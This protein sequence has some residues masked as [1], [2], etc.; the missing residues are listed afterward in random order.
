MKR[1]LLI[2]LFSFIPLYLLSQKV[3]VKITE[4]KDRYVS[5]WEILDERY[6]SISSSKEYPGTDTAVFPLEANKRYFL[7]ISVQDIEYPDTCHFSLLLN[8]EPI[9]R[10]K[11]IEPGDRL[12]PFFTG[13]KTDVDSKITGGSDADISEFPWQVY[14]EAGN[15][16]C[17]GSII[18]NE[19]IITAAHCTKGEFNEPIPASEMDVIVGANNPRNPSQGKKY[20]VSDVIVHELYDLQTYNNDIAVLRLTE[21]VN[22]TNAVPIKLISEK[23][24]IAGA[25]DPGVMSW[26]IGYGITKVNPPVYPSTLQKLKLPLV[27]NEQAS[28]VWPEIPETDMM[29]GY[30]T[31]NK[32][33]CIGDSGGPLVVPVSGGYKLAGLVSWGSTQCNTYGAY[34]RLSLFESWITEKTGIEITFRAPVPA[35][36]S[37]VCSGIQSSD[38]YVAAVSGATSYNWILTPQNS[39]TITGNAER[40]TVTWNPTFTGRV[41][42]SLQVSRNAELSEVS[43]L[44]VNVAK[45][46]SLLS[47]PG[48]TSGCAGQSL[49]LMAKAEGYNLVYKWFK[50]D[51]L[52]F[53]DTTGEYT[54]SSAG[55]KDS[56]FYYCKVGGSCGDAVT[57]TSSLTVLPVT[58]ITHITPDSEV[59]FGEDLMLEVSAEGHNLAY[60]WYKDENSL[61]NGMMSDYLLQNVDAND[62]GLYKASVSGSC[63][64]ETSSN[65]YVYVKKE[66]SRE[67]PEIYIWPT[68][69]NEEFSVALSN[70]Q[71]YN[72]LLTSNTGGLLKESRKCQYLTVI[73][74]GELAAGIY[75]VTV[76]NDYFRKSVKLIKQ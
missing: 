66:G 61:N 33:A 12:V 34:T 43:E 75:I 7:A 31:G 76:Y 56:G 8:E 36:D 17:G 46:T 24:S 53:S 69:I 64:T 62:I 15:Y 59:P 52:V 47:E 67:E 16:T 5:E 70:D 13:I 21:P 18:S 14:L 63:G 65:V 9:I 57:G 58:K 2:S 29:A 19:W 39:G 20:F 23:D 27:T 10:I 26:I 68:V 35:G 1:I 73:N 49:K 38:Y 55:A 51:T 42:I 30:L 54:I 44:I 40:I 3:S 22:Y 72:I 6:I 37:I 25:T 48:D 32:D 45:I 71:K 74:T 50:N 60:Q 28:E 11:I 4:T 41:S